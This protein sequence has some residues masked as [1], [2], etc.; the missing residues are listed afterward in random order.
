MIAH[1]LWPELHTAAKNLSPEHFKRLGITVDAAIAAGG[2]GTAKVTPLADGLFEPGG[3]MPVCLL[4]VFDGPVPESGTPWPDSRLIDIA[5]FHL[6]K[7][8][9]VWLRRGDAVLLH[10]GAAD[11]LYLDEPLRIHPTPLSWLRAGAEGCVVLDWKRAASRL[12]CVAAIDADDVEH[13]RG[14]Q[15]RLHQPSPMPDIRY[16]ERRDAA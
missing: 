1:D 16:P 5:V 12:R 3:N 10:E 13:A 9:E 14:I 8:E 7:P 4:P 2:M 6:S 11:E 15:R